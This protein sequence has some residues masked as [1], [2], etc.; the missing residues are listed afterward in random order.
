MQRTLIA[1]TGL[2]L[3]ACSPAAEQAEAPV[4]PPTPAVTLNQIQ[5]IGTHNSYK[6][7]IPGPVMELIKSRNAEAA[8]TLDYAHR[9]I[10]EQLDKGARQLEIDPYYDPQPGALADPMAPKILAQQGVQ[11]EPYDLS[12]LTKPGLK[13]LH[14]SDI[15]YR[16]S[17]HLFTGCLSQVKAWSDAHPDHAPILI[18][19]NPKHSGI[20]WEGATPVQP[21]GREALDQM[22]AEILSVFPRERL[23]TPDDVRGTAA[24]LREGALAGGWPSLEASRGKIIFAL[25]DAPERWAP[26][27]E[28]HPSLQG[29]LA[30]VHADKTPDAPE[31]AFAVMNDPVAQLA[32]IQQRVREGWLVRTR[33]DADTREARTGDKSRYEAAL[34]SGAQYISTDYLWADERFGTG[35]TAGIPG[36]VEARCNPVN[37]PEGCDL[38]R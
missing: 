29:R 6:L 3:A 4:A 38:A 1:I 16:S 22:D 35:Y 21:F 24:T 33:A 2:A 27:A 18:T 9:P 34:A 20:S 8:L 7:A 36:G 14:A 12:D 19:V 5:A 31:A 26:Y 10:A 15:D 30:F 23:V 13:V 11:L 17:C 32:D 28:G 37:A 25:D